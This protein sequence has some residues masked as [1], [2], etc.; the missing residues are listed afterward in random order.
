VVFKK[1]RY[2]Y[3]FELPNGAKALDDWSIRDLKL[4]VAKHKN[5]PCHAAAVNPRDGRVVYV[6]TKPASHKGK[7]LETPADEKEKARKEREKQH[8]AALRAREQNIAL[9]LALEHKLAAPAI[10]TD[11]M[12]L[13]ADLLMMEIGTGLAHSSFKFTDDDSQT[14]VEKKD[15]TI[16]RIVHVEGQASRRLL[17]DRLAEATTPEEIMGV[18]LQALIAARYVNRDAVPQSQRWP[19]VRGIHRGAYEPSAKAVRAAIEKIART[20]GLVA[21]PKRSRAKKAA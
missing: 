15:G 14:V 7:K 11:N 20:H 19:D 5:E 9:G 18:L 6:C 17:D 3:H 4:T 2:G 12:R 13:I 8:A 1:D 21:I 10:D 16:S